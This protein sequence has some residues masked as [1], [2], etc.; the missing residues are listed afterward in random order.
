M[1][2]T[3]VS[4]HCSP[5]SSPKLFQKCL[6]TVLNLDLWKCYIAYVKETK[7]SLRTFRWALIGNNSQATVI[8]SL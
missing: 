2:V 4:F 5:I 7:S 6:M 1:L 8:V 3:G